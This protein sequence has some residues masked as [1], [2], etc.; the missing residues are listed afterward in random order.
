MIWITALPPE[1]WAAGGSAA[2]MDTTDGFGG[3]NTPYHFP[4]VEFS[5]K[6]KEGKI[7]YFNPLSAVLH[8]SGRPS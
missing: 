1:L 8:P 2:Q 6:I 5:P 3:F 4:N 7:M